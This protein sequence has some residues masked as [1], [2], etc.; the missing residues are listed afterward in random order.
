M[1]FWRPTSNNPFFAVPRNA[2]AKCYS[3]RP[4]VAPADDATRGAQRPLRHGLPRG[5]EAGKHPHGHPG[6]EWL[7]SR[8]FVHA[9]P[10]FCT[11]SHRN[12]PLGG[13]PSRGAPCSSALISH[14]QGRGGY[15]ITPAITDHI[16]QKIG[17]SI[18][19]C[20]AVGIHEARPPVV[21]TSVFWSFSRW[22]PLTA[23]SAHR[24]ACVSPLAEALR[25]SM[26]NPCRRR[27]CVVPGAGEGC[28]P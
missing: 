20:E 10:L 1:A 11:R 16:N 5:P 13:R 2:R 14:G 18:A 25:S 22:E 8:R 3:F 27:R 4:C 9:H 28:P 15:E 6:A 7:P 12:A 26:G 23:D 19:Q 21:R 17:H 24:S